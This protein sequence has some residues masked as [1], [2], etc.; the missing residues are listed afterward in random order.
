V[1]PVFG[2]KHVDKIDSSDVLA[3]ISPIWNEVPDTASRTL[4][5]IKAVF[6]W[7]QVSGYRTVNVN[8]VLVTMP[9]PC[10]AIRSALPKQNKK[11]NHHEA[12]PYSELPDFVQKLRMA[13]FALARSLFSNS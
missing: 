10:E 1:F 8:G 4:C 11:E 12:L 13:Q 3:A 2:K 6:E 9:N 5:R 7:C